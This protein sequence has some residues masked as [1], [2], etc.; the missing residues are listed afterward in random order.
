MTNQ[1][2]RN[3]QKKH[4]LRSSKS[5]TPP[6]NNNSEQDL[7]DIRK[8]YSSESDSQDDK[9]KNKNTKKVRTSVV[10]DY[11]KHIE[12]ITPSH[13]LSNEVDTTTTTSNKDNLDSSM[14]KSKDIT[15]SPTSSSLKDSI[16]NPN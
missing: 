9:S 12:D 16:Y 15:P 4:A 1:G 3:A 14:H 6:S 8:I 13:A 5:H 10:T 2:Q 7:E 11:D